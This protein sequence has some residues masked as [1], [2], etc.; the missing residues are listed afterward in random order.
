MSP[1]KKSK[2]LKVEKEVLRLPSSMDRQIVLK[3]IPDGSTL[4]VKISR[5]SQG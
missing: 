5:K 1:E 4:K 3:D 2:T